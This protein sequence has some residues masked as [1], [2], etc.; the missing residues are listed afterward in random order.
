MICSWI[1]KQ[2]TFYVSPCGHFH[3]H[4]SFFF[5]LFF[6]EMKQIPSTFALWLIRISNFS[7]TLLLLLIHEVA[8]GSSSEQ[9]RRLCR[10]RLKIIPNHFKFITLFLFVVVD[11]INE[12]LWMTIFF[13]TLWRCFMMSLWVILNILI[14]YHK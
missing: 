9:Q 6:E 3:F 5:S 10:Q 4:Y 1:I 14:F 12:N 11:L 8:P 13:F 7:L 2:F